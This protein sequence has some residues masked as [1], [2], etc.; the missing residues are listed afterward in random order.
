MSNFTCVIKNG[1]RVVFSS[2]ESGIKPLLR[3]I[4]GNIDVKG[5]CA[6]DKIVGKAAALLYAYMGVKE[7][8]AEVMS[9]GAEEVFAQYRISHSATVRAD[10]ILNRS[11][12]G[13]CP[14]EEAVAWIF[15]PE[16]ALFAVR[17][18][19]MALVR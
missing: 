18:Q 1:D 8:H 16:E 13:I 17:S 14:M 19:M 2:D 4:D 11:G 7:V 9:Y 12:D 15:S 6:Y 5:C 3:I 10:K